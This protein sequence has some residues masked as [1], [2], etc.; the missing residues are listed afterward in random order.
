VPRNAPDFQVG[1]AF[2]FADN[3]ALVAE[4]VI[5]RKYTTVHA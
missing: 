3:L 2:L 5:K 1:L 4:H